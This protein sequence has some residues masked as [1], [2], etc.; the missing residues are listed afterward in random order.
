MSSQVDDGIALHRQG[1]FAEAEALYRAVL[2][3]SPDDAN[4]LH[5]IGLINYQAGKLDVADAF[6]TR[7]LEMDHTCA[8]TWNDL[9]A[10]KL[11][12]GN[13]EESVRYFSRALDL[14]D[15][16]TDALNNLAAAFRRLFRFESALILLRRL[17]LLRPRSSEVKLNLADTLYHVGAVEESIGAFHEVIRLDPHNKVARL[18]MA[19][20]CEAAGKFKQSRWQYIEVLR[21]EPNNPLALSKLLQMRE[22]TIN[23]N[24]V[25]QA[26]RLA[27]SGDSEIEAKTRLD[28]GLAY[29]FDK[30][31]AYDSSFRHLQ[32]A[33]ERQA[34]LQPFNSDGYSAAIDTLIEVLT[35]DFF[36][37]IQGVGIRSS[38]PIFI[39]GMPRS[40]TTLAEQILATHSRV[41]AGGELA[42]LPKAS[43][44]VQELSGDHRAYPY[45]LKSMSS[46]SAHVLAEAYLAELD[47]I[48]AEDRKVTDKLPFNFM[49]L[50]IVALLFPTAKIVHCRRDPL[51]NCMSCYFTSFAQEVQFA[52]D[53]RT[54]GRYY[55]DYR[56]LMRH[57]DEVLPINIFTLQYEDLVTRT[58]PT[59][60]S[61][62]SYCELEWEPACLKFHE[63]QRGI[64][65]P[66]RWQVRQPIYRNSVARWRHYE[67]HI[68]PLIRALGV[69]HSE[70]VS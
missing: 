25:A 45:G 35:K 48:D 9:G 47:K 24:W 64:R 69:V 51:D 42:A 49:H 38:R 6:M 13:L 10:V 59:I 19:E 21:R 67:K 4:A 70:T 22:G 61:L 12:S 29:H 43:Y 53:L 23:P 17:A 52:N 11:K 58:E 32:Q 63:T 68:E 55:S 1:R 15:Q 31:A 18:G 27:L 57:W 39:V 28:I 8:N 7:S 2:E 34:R 65:T 33:R 50:G 60:G 36:R 30:I 40:G 41:A 56:R 16:H 46:E 5:Y 44:R 66:S 3:R 62:L 20:A 14:N 54:L 26:Q 37:S